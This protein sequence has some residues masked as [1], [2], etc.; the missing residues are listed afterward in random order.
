MNEFFKE[1]IKSLSLSTQKQFARWTE[2]I[3]AKI[4]S[5]LASGRKDT[6]LYEVGLNAKFRTNPT[7][8][9]QSRDISGQHINSQSLIAAS[10][11]I[12]LTSNTRVWR[13][14]E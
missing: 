8:A 12:R 7:T 13:P 14:Q 2:P 9:A 10:K 3:V 6:L 11:T 5:L 1:E 4:G